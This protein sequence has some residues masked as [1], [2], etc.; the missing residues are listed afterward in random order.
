MSF[1]KNLV[2]TIFQGFYISIL[3]FLLAQTYF[4]PKI[5][6]K[7]YPYTIR[8]AITNLNIM[9]QNIEKFL[10]HGSFYDSIDLSKAEYK[11][12][13]FLTPNI[14]YALTYSGV[15]DDFGG[16]VFM[17]KANSELNIFNASNIDD[18][19]TLLAAFPEYKEY[20]DNMAEYE[21]LEC[22]EKV[23]DQKKII[24]DIKS[25]GYDGYFN[26]ENKPMS[27]AKPFY[28]NL[29]KSESYCIFSTDKVELVD[30]YMKDEI[31]DNLDFKKAR[32]EDEALFKKEIKEYLDSGLTEEE[33]IEKYE[34]DT[35]NQYVTIPVLEAV[36][37][38][39]DVADEL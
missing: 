11:E 36:D 23:A 14:R 35:E 17:Y 13:L 28:K 26:W 39:Q 34:S 29:E 37:I 31:E 8:I 15:D 38:V 25:L 12:C 9:I 2:F 30:V 10:Y 32:Q 4:T 33:I 27:G 19:E 5:F 24:S 20:I 21:W 3:L 7:N 22:F 18:R 16:Y 1:V 6:E